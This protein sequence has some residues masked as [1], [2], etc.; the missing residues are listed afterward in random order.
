M[1]WTSVDVGGAKSLLSGV[2]ERCH[3][4][5]RRGLNALGATA[6]ARRLSSVS[7]LRP[8]FQKP[9]AVT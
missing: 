2:R 7:P 9:R 6:D 8:C 1:E 3:W 5:L 4:S